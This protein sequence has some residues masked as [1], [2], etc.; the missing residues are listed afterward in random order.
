LA[1][2]LNALQAQEQRRTI[3]Q[4]ESMEGAFLAKM[5]VQEGDK[6][7]KKN[8]KKIKEPVITIKELETFLLVNTVRKQITYINITGGDLMLDAE[9]VI[10]WDT[11]KR[12][13][14]VELISKKVKLKLLINNKRSSCLWPLAWLVNMQ[15]ITDL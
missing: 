5:Q 10:N 4:E 3:R 6:G 12:F 1:E 11:W 14:K 7:K 9:N 8:K 13:A 2:L 15:V